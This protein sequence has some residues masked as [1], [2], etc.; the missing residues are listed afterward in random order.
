MW[1]PFNHTL[2]LPE[3]GDLQSRNRMKFRRVWR[4]DIFSGDAGVIFL[5]LLFGVPA[6]LPL[7]EPV[8]TFGHSALIDYCRVVELDR[9]LRGGDLY[10]RWLP[11]L[12][13]GRG[14]PLF[15]FYAP[16]SYD[17][18]VLGTWITGSVLHG[19]K[20][21]YLL[22]FM[23]GGIL[24][25]LWGR[26]FWGRWG[27]FLSGVLYLY[28]PYHL[29]D[30][31]V[32]SNVAEFTAISLL[33]LP[34]LALSAL[35]SGGGKGWRVAGAIGVAAITLAHNLTAFLAVPVVGGYAAWLGVKRR[36]VW[37]EGALIL[38]LGVGL[39]AFFWIPALAE[40]DFVRLDESVR[41]GEFHYADHFVEPW[42]FLDTTW[43]FG[44]SRPGPHDGISFQI[45]TV[46]LFLS[47]IALLLSFR[48][49][50]R[51]GIRFFLL[52]F[53]LLLWI[54]S[55]LMMLPLSR[56][57]WDRIPLLPYLQFPWRFLLLSALATSLLGGSV[58]LGFDRP[59]VGRAAAL[60]F[61]CAAV[62][63]AWR[64]GQTKSLY[65]VWN[66]EHDAPENVERPEEATATA[67]RRPI[68]EVLTIDWI[69]RHPVTTTAKFDYLPRSVGRFPLPPVER[70]VS[71]DPDRVA[72]G[73]IESGPVSLR[74]VAE[75]TKP[76]E[77]T[78][79]TFD[80]PGW[81]VETEGG[82]VPHHP[83]EPTGEICFTLEPGRH[84]VRVHFGTTPLRRRA[85]RLS[86][87][88]LLLL[89]L[90]LRWPRRAGPTSE[91]SFRSTPSAS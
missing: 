48:R 3:G 53:L 39:C 40:R 87:L 15:N 56:P 59:G 45:G 24:A 57:L 86:L 18:A 78:V 74:F 73:E 65:L 6:V 76:A 41:G 58:V 7:L 19:V 60:F 79:H 30:V 84:R 50:V 89:L 49:E 35:A 2:S 85:A 8:Q 47:L 66:T 55:M 71:G 75:V 64:G 51:G 61:A 69:R 72:I 91:A 36:E 26:I 10:P 13:V 52:S 20:F 31:Y 5:L 80:Y 34:F 42:Q 25:F 21:C 33:P 54:G 63:L 67:E 82:V 46:H 9:C 32:R 68:E 29:V 38:L 83:C 27:G 44:T 11:D 4:R 37:R 1:P 23:M 88:S 43:H 70:P 90:S 81:R 28:A 77:L 17:L 14:Y 62:V 22:G 12:C 16:L